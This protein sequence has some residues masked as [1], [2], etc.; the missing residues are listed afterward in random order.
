MLN[1]L[2]KI[3]FTMLALF[4]A[5]AFC[6]A[7][8]L[9]F[10]QVSDVH[11]TL[12]NSELEKYLYFLSLSVKKKQPDFLVFLGDNVDKSREED[13]I[14]FMR[15]IH[16]IRTPY[17]IVLGKNDAHQLS[18]LE[19]EVYLDIVTT[20]NRN[21]K[22]GEKYY[23]FKPNSHFICVVLDDTPDFAPSKHGEIPQEQLDWLEK[24]LIKYPKRL[25]LI[26]HH[27][28]LNPPRVEY[29]LSMLNSDKYKDLIKKYPN[30][31]TISSGHYHQSAVLTDEN[32]VKHISAPAFKDIPHSYQ[33]IQIIYD[34]DTY[35]S[36][37]D[38]QIN[39]TQVKV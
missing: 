33:L 23:Y 17:Y 15:A 1:N 36:P 39:V 21:Q 14:G 12:G 20:F 24:L 16:S 18:G 30:I 8:V 25:F 9:E 26:F 37:A 7:D 38:V 22:D 31:I 28:P 19:K 11:Y 35:K 32:G 6:N 13:V 5:Q 27:T 3:L 34:M 2:K 29:K 4:C 10:A